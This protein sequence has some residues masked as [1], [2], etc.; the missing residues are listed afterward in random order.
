ME[1]SLKKRI[2]LEI[3]RSIKNNR[4]KLHELRQLFWECTLRCNLHC[5]HCGSACLPK[6]QIKDMP[7]EDF[8]RVIDNL[9]PHV[10][11]H[12]LMIIITG[13]EPLLRNDIEYVGQQ[14]Y[15]RE[16]PWGVVSNGM[17]LTVGRLKA[18]INSGMRSATISLDGNEDDHNYMR[19]NS[20][21]WQRAFNA[22]RLLGKT[23]GL[24]WDVA[25]CV[26]PRSLDGL[27]DLKKRLYDVGVE[28]WRVFSAFPAGRAAENKD[29]QLNGAQLRQLMDFIIE[30][31]AEGKHVSYSCEGF[32]GR[33]EN[34]VRDNFYS[35]EAG[36]SVASVM[37]NGDISACPGI[38]AVF[39]QGN[40]YKDD[41]WNVWNNK[42]Q[43]FR[44]RSWAKTGIC[45]DCKF[46]RY[47][48]GGGMHLHNAD[49]S[50]MMCHLERLNSTES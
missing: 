35:C 24:N 45:A 39:S 5:R 18:L 1:L 26:T 32:L 16:Y 38:R 28:S 21:S 2:G 34:D 8:L 14:L 17:L 31:R 6:S 37:S 48:E 10:D 27:H 25:T 13:G 44:N 20:E 43:K 12:S 41:L 30:C 9:T 29:L 33:Y 50:L 23:S 4:K 42:F 22:I 11:T 36:V 49:N 15:K 3:A 7:A 40:I 19:G 46:F 47:C